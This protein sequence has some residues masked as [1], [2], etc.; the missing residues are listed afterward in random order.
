[1]AHSLKLAQT[2]TIETSNQQRCTFA[3]K[4]KLYQA[5]TPDVS[6]IDL[7]FSGEVLRISSL[8]KREAQ[9]PP[10]NLEIFSFGITLDATSKKI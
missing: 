10:V 8:T 4:N 2:R 7:P 3:R 9:P 5:V 6:S 1:V